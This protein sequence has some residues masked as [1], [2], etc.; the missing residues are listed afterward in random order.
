MKPMRT[1]TCATCDT[2]KPVDE[3]YPSRLHPDGRAANCIL[4]M[5]AQPLVY[6]A[7]RACP[8]EQRRKQIRS[9]KHRRR[10]AYIAGSTE[11]GWVDRQAIIER[12]GSICYLCRRKLELGEIT[13]DHVIPL[14]K[15]GKHTPENVRVCCLLCNI[16][17]GDKI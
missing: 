2:P 15:G 3:F 8:G 11:V 9:E 13:L 7:W 10:R 16:R 12:D 1:K 4:C 5:G 6:P 14:S 17:K